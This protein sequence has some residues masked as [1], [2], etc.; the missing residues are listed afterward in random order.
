M[1]YINVFAIDWHNIYN[2][3]IAWMGDYYS[4]T[5]PGFNFDNNY[6]N[7]IL[8]FKE[9]KDLAVLNKFYQLLL[10]FLDTKLPT[11]KSFKLATI[12]RSKPDS[13][14]YGFFYLFDSI[15]KRQ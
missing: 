15:E 13:E 14:K 10:D 4:P 3:K 2:E 9:G 6:S 1:A 11:I 5:N 8:L 12:P 7:D